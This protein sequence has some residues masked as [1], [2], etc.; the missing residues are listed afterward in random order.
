MARLLLLCG[1]LGPLG[2]VGTLGSASAQGRY[3]RPPPAPVQVTL[4]ERVRAPRPRL[5]APDRRK[6]TIGVEAVL[7][8]PPRGVAREE[9]ER[10]LVELIADTP[11]SAVEEKSDLYFRLAEVYA[12]QH[13]RWRLE[14]GPAAP[15][16]AKDY[17]LKAVK[18]YRALTDN[19]AFA[20]YPKLDAAL[21]AYG[22]TLQAGK[23]LP[24]ARIVFKKL[25]Q[26]FPNSAYVPQA[27]LV[28][29][30]YYF[31]ANQ[32][33]EAEAFYKKVLEFPRSEVYGY[34][35][36]KQGWVQW[37]LQRFP[38]ALA[39]FFQVVQLTRA[40]PKQRALTE[41]AKQGALETYVEI[42][43][44]QKASAV[45]ARLDPAQ[46]VE[47]LGTLADRYAEDGKSP[48][49]IALY[50]ELIKT[51]PARAFVCRWQY[52]AA[53][54]MQGSPSATTADKVREIENLV[55]AY[56]AL[57]ANKVLPDVEAQE[58]HDNAAAMSGELARVYHLEAAKTRTF[59]ALTA[60]EA[61]YKAHA[62][63]FP[64]APDAAELRG[65]YADLL[66]EHAVAE[67]SPRLQPARWAA[68]AD[69]LAAAAKI[70]TEP[71]RR[72]ELVTAAMLA[73]KNALDIDPRLEVQAGT[74]DLEAAA[75]A[76]PQQRELTAAETSVLETF[77][78]YGAQ[79]T[80]RDELA[81]TKFLTAT[82]A[83]RYGQHA[84]AIPVLTDL[85][86]RYRDQP[87]A[88]LA[89]NLLLDSMIRLQQYDQVLAL[90]D[91]LAADKAF[92]AGKPALV[93]NIALL[94]S[95]S[96]RRR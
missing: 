49:A 77:E 51:A 26:D 72:A 63:A 94:R 38:E 64:D 81:R 59:E 75:R 13:Q 47:L 42:G 35:L 3:S 18:T 39:L 11:D 52:G 91:T 34:A 86:E 55:K 43:T 62:D 31:E 6:P 30:D 76:R 44:P 23:Y 20:R 46:S 17:L 82:L 15:G 70:T 37:N 67:V 41:A 22:S 48:Q 85:V 21:F 96:L 5:A 83:R 56:V 33:P 8:S 28:F 78:Y 57:N 50:R 60:A 24:E 7:G 79:L 45:F 68:A 80:E 40:D 89:T 16:K 61:L 19:R 27:E 36:Y 90:V 92:L 95:R 2:I 14:A 69:E 29:A 93:K 4:S 87:T 66:W 32:L 58:C 74:I 65:G 12:Q 25:L 54:A 10:L 73:R 71:R 88:E 84:R 9:T 53:R 1:L